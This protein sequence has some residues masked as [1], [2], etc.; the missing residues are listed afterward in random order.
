MRITPNFNRFYHGAVLGD[1]YRQMVERRAICISFERFKGALKYA[2]KDYPRTADGE[3]A[4]TKDV[5]SAALTQ[6]L[7]W[8]RVWAAEYGMTL[9]VDDEE[10][11]RIARE[12]RE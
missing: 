8:V 2:N 12:I 3:L 10:W 7:E 1:L 11:E 6:H 9:T 5:S 4:S